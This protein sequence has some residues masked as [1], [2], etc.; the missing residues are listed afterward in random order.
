MLSYNFLTKEFNFVCNECADIVSNVS[1][2]E[3][4]EKGWGLRLN[5]SGYLSYCLC[6]DCKM[7]R[8]LEDIREMYGSNREDL[9]YDELIAVQNNWYNEI[10]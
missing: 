3:I 4:I 6:P 9:S 2:N 5:D 10:T 8:D 7:G 1:I